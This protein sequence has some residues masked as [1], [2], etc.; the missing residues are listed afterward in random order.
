ME[1][2]NEIKLPTELEDLV[3]R[4]LRNV[5]F[6]PN[7]DS[8]ENLLKYQPKEEFKRDWTQY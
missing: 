8:Q 7:R 3:Q 1:N 2:D 6:T 4:A 5:K